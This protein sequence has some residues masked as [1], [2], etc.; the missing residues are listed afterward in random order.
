MGSMALFPL[1]GLR[2]WLRPGAPS[3]PAA[4]RQ[5]RN[6]GRRA[7]AGKDRRWV[8]CLA[9][10]LR[11]QLGG[12]S[13]SVAADA[14][15]TRGSNAAGSGMAALDALADRVTADAKSDRRV[16]L[17]E[18]VVVRVRPR[19]VLRRPSVHSTAT[20]ASAYAALHEDR[21]NV[22]DIAGCSSTLP[23]R[24]TSLRHSL[25]GDGLDMQTRRNDHCETWIVP[26]AASVL[27]ISPSTASTRPDCVSKAPQAALR[28]EGLPRPTFHQLRLGAASLLLLSGVP[29]PVVSRLLGHSTV[30]ITLD[31]DGRIGVDVQLQAAAA[32]DGFFYY[33]VTW[34]SGRKW[35]TKWQTMG[36][37]SSPDPFLSLD[38]GTLRTQMGGEGEIRT[39]EAFP[40][41]CFQ[42]SCLQPLGHLS[43][44]HGYAT[45]AGSHSPMSDSVPRHGVPVQPRAAARAAVSRTEPVSCRT[46]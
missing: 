25:L 32:M 38:I 7:P 33:V 18:P 17:G 5:R 13:I 46:P 37:A 39:R 31:I 12:A 2:R 43:T 26:E 20:G 19:A 42:D 21:T 4:R 22:R 23:V 6:W 1:G 36:R 28:A 8:D 44:G 11:C 24:P 29:L 16:R 34:P 45:T 40:P 14:A 3:P 9:V 15:A 41:G 35:S 10:W 27:G 30:A